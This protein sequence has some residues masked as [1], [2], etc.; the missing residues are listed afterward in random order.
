MAGLCSLSYLRPVLCRIL[1]RSGLGLVYVA[2]PAWAK[3]GGSPDHGGFPLLAPFSAVGL[4]EVSRRRRKLPLH[5]AG[6]AA[7]W[8]WGKGDEQLILMGA[9]FLVAF[10]SG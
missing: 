8:A 4:Y 5:L 6:A 3:A 10:S 9:S 7:R 1:R 2:D